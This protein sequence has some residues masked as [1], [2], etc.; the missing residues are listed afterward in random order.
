[1]G[2][3]GEPVLSSVDDGVLRLVLNRPERRNSLDI[4]A[5]DAV[6][7]ALE[8]AAISDSL[9]VIVLEGAGTDFCSGADWVA[10]N[11]AGSPAGGPAAGSAGQASANGGARGDAAAQRPRAGSLQRRT[12]LQAHRI[13]QLLLEVQLPVVAVVRGWAAGLGFQLAL[14]A[15]F[16]VAADSARF[17]EPFIERGFTPDS[18]S[19]W[20]LPRLVGLARAR[21]LLLL[22]RTLT[23]AEAASW[24]LIHTSVAEPEVDATAAA[25]IERLASGPTVALGLAKR[26]LTRNLEEPL[27]HALDNESLALELSSRTSDFREGLA[28]FTQRRPANFTGR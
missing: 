7:R 26:C 11:S 20:L 18:G 3:T 5:V 13:I 10:S 12:P 23:G 27:P 1:M 24:G 2:T 16:T 15:D 25:L 28:A 6:I 9:R 8:A 19:T 21:E 14:A 17:W 22:G 4:A